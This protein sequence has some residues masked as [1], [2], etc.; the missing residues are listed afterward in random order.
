MTEPKDIFEQ[1]VSK[2]K[3][4]FDRIKL[5]SKFFD[6]MNDANA[7]VFWVSKYREKMIEGQKPSL[8]MN[9]IIWQVKWYD[10]LSEEDRQINI[11]LYEKS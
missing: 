10:F 7:P 4:I 8:D 3:Q 6:I 1:S 5:Q 2:H 9:K 11:D